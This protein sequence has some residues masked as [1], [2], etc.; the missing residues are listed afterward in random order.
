MIRWCR[1]GGLRTPVVPQL[2][3]CLERRA[4]NDH[5]HAAAQPPRLRSLSVR[6]ILTELKISR[7][8]WD[9]W[10]VTGRGPQAIKLRDGQL[11]IREDWFDE[12]LERQPAA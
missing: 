9:T 12:W 2:G 5:P 7:S 4:S 3:D 6:E 1:G 11:R 8:T 10:L